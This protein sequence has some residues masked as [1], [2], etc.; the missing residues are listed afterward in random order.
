MPGQ[1]ISMPGQHQQHHHIPA[2]GT[3]LLP[4]QA[5]KA[6]NGQ[7]QAPGLMYIFSREVKGPFIITTPGIFGVTI[8]TE[9]GN[10]LAL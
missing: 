5:K 7:N 10:F 4:Q 8:G 3:V 6:K 9:G 2:I 1:E